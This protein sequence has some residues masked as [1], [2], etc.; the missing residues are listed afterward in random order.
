MM[1]ANDPPG[2]S[3]TTARGL[4]AWASSAFETAGVYCGHGTATPEEE[5]AW[6]VSA[7]CPDGDDGAPLDEARCRRGV[8]LAER[9]I[10]ERKPLAYLLK[11]AWFAGHAFFVDERVLVPRS[12]IAELIESRFSPWLRPGP[13]DTILEIGTGSG[14]IASLLTKI[15]NLEQRLQQLEAAG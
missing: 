10:R 11:E 14:R 6:L 15:Q 8:A 13:V 2:P 1:I 4:V 5:A 12:P 7:V 9:R 3:D